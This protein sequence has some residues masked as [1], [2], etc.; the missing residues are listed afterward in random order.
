MVDPAAGWLEVAT[1]DERELLT[2]ASTVKLNWLAHYPR[3]NSITFDKGT[4]FIGHGIKSMVEKDYS[5]RGKECTTRN[6]QANAILDRLH[7]C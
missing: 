6:P 7:R 5:M 1:H 2:I 4:E 3:P